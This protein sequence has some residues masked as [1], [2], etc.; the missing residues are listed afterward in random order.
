MNG[1]PSA[2]G[3]LTE[4]GR[5]QARALGEAL[6]GEEIELC[7]VTPFERVRET[8]DLAL[9]GRDVPRL[10]V[11]E[12]SDPGYGSFEGGR[13]DAYR[14]WV[15]THGPLDAPPGGESRAEIAAR[16]ARGL[17]LLLGRPERL[18]L[19]VAHSLTIRYALNAA[20]GRAPQAR[21]SSWSSPCRSASKRTSS[22]PRS[23]CSRPGARPPP[24]K[25]GAVRA[26][27][28][29]AALLAALAVLES[30]RLEVERLQ[31]CTDG[32]DARELARASRRTSA[33]TA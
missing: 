13:L 28:V 19:L 6:R 11:P 31:Q 33:G 2:P 1:D 18:I 23:S 27:A 10:V 3:P 25:I 32:V 22:A 12:L 30:I 29:L 7:A 16:Y 5:E 24:S 26:R 14:D 8:A 21:A 20:A 17:R 4:A 15:W 9:A